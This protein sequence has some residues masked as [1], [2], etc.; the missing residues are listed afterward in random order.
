MKYLRK[1]YEI[2][3]GNLCNI[4][5]KS[6]KYLK[7][8]FEIFLKKHIFQGNPSYISRKPITFFKETRLICQANP[9]YMSSKPI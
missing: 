7:E 1:T 4:S 9:L 8:N 6:M 5:R 3:Q 2:S